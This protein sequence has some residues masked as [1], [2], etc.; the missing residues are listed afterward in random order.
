MDVVPDN[1]KID[2]VHHRLE[3]EELK[4]PICGTEMVE[5][6][7]EERRTLEIIPEQVIVHVDIYH[8]YAYKEFFPRFTILRVP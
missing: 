5:I 7:G 1:V 4:C 2:E 8:N 6:G 3:G